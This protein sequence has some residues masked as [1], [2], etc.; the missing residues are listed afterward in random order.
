M[1]WIKERLDEIG[2]RPIELSRALGLPPARAYEMIKGV[3]RIQPDEIGRLAAFLDWPESHVVALIDG[4]ATSKSGK[5]SPSAARPPIPTPAGRARVPLASEAFR[6]GRPDIPVWAAAQAGEDGAL[7]LV[8]DPVDYIFRSERMRGVRNPFAFQ[9]VGS[10][11]SPALEHGDQVVINP[12]LLV[13][14]GVD[15]VFIQQQRD[16]TFLALVK[17]LLRQTADSWQ[18]RQYDPKKDFDLPKKK[19]PRAHV[20]A[21]IRRGGL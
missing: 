11:M 17:R 19:W 20:V 4:R 8:P 15:C 10:S 13:R 7:I 1:K 3:R 14:P 5:R 9:I 18:V 12:A 21:E 2:R 6:E 16:G